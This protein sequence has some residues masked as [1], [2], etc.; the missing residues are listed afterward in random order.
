[1]QQAVLDKVRGGGQ[2]Q[3]TEDGEA[4]VVAE[5]ENTSGRGFDHGL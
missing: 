3:S 4:I 5:V 1:M 2:A